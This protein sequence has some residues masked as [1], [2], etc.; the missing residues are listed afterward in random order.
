MQSCCFACARIAG[1]SGEI[2]GSPEPVSD[3]HSN[4]GS[5]ASSLRKRSN[6]RTGS[7]RS[8]SGT[9]PW[10]R[11]TVEPHWMQR[12]LQRCSALN[13]ISNG[14]VD[15]STRRAA[16][17]A[18]TAALLRVRLLSVMGLVRCG[19]GALGRERSWS[20]A[21]A[22]QAGAGAA[23]AAGRSVRRDEGLCLKPG[24]RTAEEPGTR[25]S[26]AS[27]NPTRGPPCCRVLPRSSSW[28]CSA[29]AVR[30]SKRHSRTAP[31]ALSRSS[32]R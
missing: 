5:A 29:P 2:S 20:V 17:S 7:L 24:P 31:R 3:S 8:I 23:P 11:F 15:T 9:I 22:S 32:P 4:D 12:R 10:L 27:R 1:R 19:V 25:R 28:L 6:A 18:V 14:K 21:G 16:I 30:P 26:P 13:W